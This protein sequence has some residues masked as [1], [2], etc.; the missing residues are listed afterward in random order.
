MIDKKLWL[1][2]ICVYTF[3]I[4]LGYYTSN[5][6]I[7]TNNIVVCERP[8]SFYI[9]HNCGFLIVGLLGGTFLGTGAFFVLSINGFIGGRYLYFLIHL[10]YKNGII[11]MIPHFLIEASAVIISS[12]CGL[13]LGASLLKYLLK[14]SDDLFKKEL[15]KT[16]VTYFVISFLLVVIGGIVES[17]VAT[18]SLKQMLK[19]VSTDI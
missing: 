9:F 8:A 16:V 7:T 10:P 15:I 19:G 17:T 4:S 5:A 6:S 12:A 14:K 2:S 3:A 13:A 11:F 18:N 1:I